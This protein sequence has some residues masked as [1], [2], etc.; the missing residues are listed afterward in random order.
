MGDV[1]TVRGLV[2]SAI[3]ALSGWTPS[4]F[5]PEL[6]GRDT[7]GLVHHSFAVAVPETE[8]HARDGRQRVAEG[9]LVTSRVEVYW[10]HRLRADAQS[11]DY[12]AAANAEDDLVAAVRA[13]SN[14]H[15]LVQR[16]TRRAVPEGW[17]LGTVTFTVLHRYSLT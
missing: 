5:A 6:F 14:A 1:A 4:R 2:T 7:D 8:V 12:D 11:T 13:I 10:A 17:V 3:D 15:V 9:L 16:M